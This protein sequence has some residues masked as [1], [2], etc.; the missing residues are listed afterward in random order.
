[1]RTAKREATSESDF[2][3][4]ELQLEPH[5]VPATSV[6]AFAREKACDQDVERLSLEIE[7]SKERHQELAGKQSDL[8]KES[9]RYE[10]MAKRYENLSPTTT[11]ESRFAGL[12]SKDD[13]TTEDFVRRRRRVVGDLAAVEKKLGE[14]YDTEIAPLTANP[15]LDK[16]RIPFRETLKRRSRADFDANA[17]VYL[18]DIQQQIAAYQHE[19]A[20][21]EQELK[22]IVGQLDAIARRTTSLLGQTETAS[23]MPE[24][25]G[26]WAG[27]SFLR[28]SVPKKND[29]A[30]RSALL[31]QAL[32]TWYAREKIPTGHEL[33]F[34]CVY[35]VCGAKS[36]IVKLLKP[37]YHLSP[38]QH[39]ITDLV[40]FSD[41][42]KLTAAILLY[43]VLIRLRARQRA[44]SLS[45][46]GDSGT[47][48]RMP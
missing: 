1:M 46:G 24:G 42:E 40:K 37:E 12:F 17:A 32:E 30:E 44:K 20:S 15:D 33:A 22:I 11:S 18:P 2:K 5:E 39:E 6:D 45:P 47:R 26:A 7:S 16:Y 13:E 3:A 36:I 4:G 10:G 48:E 43:C 19:L 21:E 8:E 34:A 27:H 25:L 41:G 28:I 9:A 23:R 14:K 31:G 35:A 38:I 29:E